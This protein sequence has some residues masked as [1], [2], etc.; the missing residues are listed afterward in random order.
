LPGRLP[1]QHTNWLIR[2]IIDRQY[3]MVFCLTEEK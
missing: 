1:A 2:I 3:K